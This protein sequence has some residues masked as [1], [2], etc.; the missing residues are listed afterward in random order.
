[1]T[2]GRHVRAMF[3]SDLVN[4]ESDNTDDSA[5]KAG[6]SSREQEQNI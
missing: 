5:L 3:V 2:L 6:A 1:M 4:S